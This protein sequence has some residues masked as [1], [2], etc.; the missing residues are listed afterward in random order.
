MIRVVRLCVSLSV[1]LCVL[2][3]RVPAQEA[4][5]SAYLE[6]FEADA[7]QKAASW[8]KQAQ[9][10]ES[11]VAHMLPCDA[12]AMPTITAVSQASDARLA[13][14]AAYLQA[15]QNEASRETAGAQRIVASAQSL[16]SELGAEKADVAQEHSAIDA[17]LAALSETVSKRAA[18][19][20]AQKTLQQIQAL[21]AQRAELAQGG[22][23]RQQAFLTSLRNL[24]ASL[25]ARESALKAA[26]VAYE[27]ERARWNAYYA[28]RLARAQIE[29]NIT[30]APAPRPPGKQP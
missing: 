1:G 13:A 14:V 9:A 18:L 7:R 22:L 26:Q 5:G 29:C 3:V 6:P 11:S 27:A 28:A 10:M 25:E 20:D 24:A 21:T 16:V 8:V 12:R 30:R 19:G 2:A 23:D 15:A 4:P 17:Q